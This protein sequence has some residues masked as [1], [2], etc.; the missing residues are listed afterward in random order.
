MRSL[1]TQQVALL[2]RGEYL[3]REIAPVDAADVQLQAGVIMR[4]IGQRK[5]AATSVLEQDVDV[6]SWEEI[7][8]FAGRQAEFDEHHIRR[9]EG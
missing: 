7:E 6:L 4:R 8:A 3:S 9:Y 1:D 5:G 2:Q